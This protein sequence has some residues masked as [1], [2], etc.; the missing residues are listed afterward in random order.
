MPVVSGAI[1]IAAL[2]VGAA[3]LLMANKSRQNLDSNV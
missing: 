2:D 3:W 1:A